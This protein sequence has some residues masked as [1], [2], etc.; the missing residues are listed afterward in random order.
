M[1]IWFAAYIPENSCG[2]IASSM[3]GLS[4][5]LSSR[6]HKVR[7]IYRAKGFMGQNYILFAV[8]LCM[9]LF[10]NMKTTPD[11]IIAR[12]SDGVFCALMVKLLRLKT[13]LVLHS[14]GWEEIA[15]LAEKSVSTGA[16]SHP[17]TWK[18]EIIRFQLLRTAFYMS[19]YCFTGTIS[20]ARWLRSQ[21]PRHGH[22]VRYMP[23]G[24]RINGNGFWVD[25]DEVPQRFLAVG[26]ATWKKNHE[27][28]VELFEELLKKMPAARLYIAGAGDW[29]CKNNSVTVV[30]YV[31][32]SRMPELYASCPYFISSSVYEGGHSYAI[33]EAMSAG[34]LIFASGIDSSREIIKNGYNGFI[35]NIFNAVNDAETVISEVQNVAQ[36]RY[37]RRNAVNTAYRNRL[38]RQVDRLERAL[39]VWQ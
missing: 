35:I 23:N 6:G 24:I 33:L 19:R 16:V 21:Y 20:E 34:C 32:P 36:S 9:K 14:H 3:R 29:I 12:S 2:G 15:A 18:A 27:Y 10:R 25:K 11:L 1:N 28:T 17:T 31:L 5:C 13:G 7:I 30:P 26:P 22:K 4:E 39:C 38:E 8:Y 37:I